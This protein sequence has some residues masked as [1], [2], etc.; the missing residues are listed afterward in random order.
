MEQ[1]S[2]NIP[3]E[4]YKELVEEAGNVPVESYIWVLISRARRQRPRLVVVDTVDSFLQAIEPWK[5]LVDAGGMTAYGGV[6]GG[7]IRTLPNGRVRFTKEAWFFAMGPCIQ[8]DLV[9]GELSERFSSDGKADPDLI[10]RAKQTAVP[11]ERVAPGEPPLDDED[12][13]IFKRLNEVTDRLWPAL[14]RLGVRRQDRL[15]PLDDAT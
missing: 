10:I 2:I 5:G 7:S 9:V 4:L 14:E 13:A 15:I 11:W 12:K 6:G 1:V 3:M 8:G